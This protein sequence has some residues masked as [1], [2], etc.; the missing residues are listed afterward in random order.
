V[1]SFWG[2]TSFL[3]KVVIPISGN[4]ENCAEHGSRP[5]DRE[6]ALSIIESEMNQVFL[7]QRFDARS[8]EEGA[9]AESCA[10]SP[11]EVKT[12]PSRQRSP[13]GVSAP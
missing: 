2:P 7:E 10:Y 9:R 5:L 3:E 12:H 1:T 11:L 13:V 6:P 4:N 8:N